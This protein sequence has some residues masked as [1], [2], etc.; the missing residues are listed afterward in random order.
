MSKDYQY[1]IIQYKY[2]CAYTYF[3][4]PYFPLGTDT[5]L[6]RTDLYWIAELLNIWALMKTDLRGQ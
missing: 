3:V 6:N 5:K 1:C 4:I 2:G